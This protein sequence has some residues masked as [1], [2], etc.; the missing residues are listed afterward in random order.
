VSGLTEQDVAAKIPRN[1]AIGVLIAF[2]V[3]VLSLYPLASVLGWRSGWR[4][5]LPCSPDRS[6]VAC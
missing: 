5:C 1:I 3:T 4:W 6:S 2:V